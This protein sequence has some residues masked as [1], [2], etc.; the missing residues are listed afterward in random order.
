MTKR[1]R[2]K[3]GKHKAHTKAIERRAAIAPYIR[4]LER[5]RVPRSTIKSAK[6]AMLI[7]LLGAR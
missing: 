2:T 7:L 4:E 5:S 1:R 3:P 6:T